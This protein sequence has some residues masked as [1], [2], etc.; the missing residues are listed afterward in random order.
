VKWWTNG[1]GRE[2]TDTRIHTTKFLREGGIDYGSPSFNSAMKSKYEADLK[3]G[4]YNIYTG[5]NKGSGEIESPAL[6]P[7]D[8]VAG[9]LTGALRGATTSSVVNSG[10]VFW[11]GGDFAKNA[12]AEFAKANGL[13]T[14]EMTMTGRIMNS[15]S[16]FVPRSISNPIWK[17]M[18]KRFASSTSSKAHFFTTSSGPR[19]TSIWLSVE[20]PILEKNGVNIITHQP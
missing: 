5:Y 16:P 6:D 2:G 15:I 9:G 13:R 4:D 17:N 3:V 7:I 11:S 14:L 19:A 8:F 18:S 20:K 1:D 12:A 10:H